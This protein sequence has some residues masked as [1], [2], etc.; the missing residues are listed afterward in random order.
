MHGLISSFLENWTSFYSNHAV[1][2]TF[3]GFFHIGGLV[4]GG[5]CAIAADRSILLA[6]KRTAAEKSS[7][8]D[9]LRGTHRIVLISLAVV[10]VSGLFL[11]AAD[12]DNFLHSILFWVKMGLILALMANGFLLVRAERRAETDIAGAW[13]ALKI[14]STVSVALWMLTTLV[15]AALPNIG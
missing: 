15:G 9:A 14:T 5:G 3:I 1:I 13:R 7:Q 8:V 6:S 12:S 4:L 11:F 2:R 10:I